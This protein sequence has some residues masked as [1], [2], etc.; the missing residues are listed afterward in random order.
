MNFWLGGGGVYAECITRLLNALPLQL[1]SSVFFLCSSVAYAFWNFRCLVVSIF[2]VCRR[3]NVSHT[4]LL[5]EKIEFRWKLLVMLPLVPSITITYFG[6]SNFVNSCT[7]QVTIEKELRLLPSCQIPSIIPAQQTNKKHTTNAPCAHI[8][9][10]IIWFRIFIIFV[11]LYSKSNA[12]LIWDINAELI[13]LHFTA[14]SLCIMTLWNII[15][16]SLI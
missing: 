14:V 1:S 9:K 10:V 6:Y 4:C 13:E 8:H 15:E 2:C 5:A 3:R 12:I 7:L 11:V 16:T